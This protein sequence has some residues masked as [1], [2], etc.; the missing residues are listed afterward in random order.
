MKKLLLTLALTILI[1]SPVFSQLDRSVIPGPGPAPE[2]K[3]GEYESFEL[4]N[5]LKVFVV[6]NHKL[7]RVA[8]N[9]ILDIDPILE[10]NNAGYISATGDLLR[11]GTKTRTKDQIDNEVDFIGAT[12]N[13]SST[14]VY[15][16][17]LKKQV[18]KLLELM[19]DVVLNSEFKQE[20]LDKIK[21]Q[22]LS[23][24]AAQKKDPDAISKVVGDAIMYGKKHPYGEVMTKATVES[25]TKDMCENYYKTY[26]RPNAAY[27]AVVGDITKDEAKNLI[28][29]YF[30]N[31]EK[32]DVPK[33]N[34]KTPTQPRVDNVAIVDRPSS[35]QSVVSV[36]Y[37]VDL[38]K[39][40]PDVMPSSVMNTILGGS[41]LSRLNHNIREDKGWTYG[42][43]SALRSDEVI[44]Y[45]KAGTTVRNSVTDSTVT[46]ILYEMN[47]LRNEKVPDEELQST[48]NYI[49][50]SFAR[51]LENPQTI[52]NFALNI[53]RYDL[54]KNYYTNYLKNLN[55]VTADDIQRVAKE[56]LKTQNAY[57]VIVGN[58]GEVAD[59][60][61]KF[62]PGGLVNYYD[63]YGDP[64]DPSVNQIEEGV[65]VQS[66]IDAYINAI[67][68]RENIQKVHD[69]TVT[70]KGKAMGSDI[71]FAVYQ[72]APNKYYQFMD[73]G[74]FTQKVVFDG[75][76]GKQ[77]QMGQKEY[78]TG[79]ELES[80]KIDA[81][82]NAFL[83]YA[84]YNIKPKL[85]GKEKVNDKECYRV[86][87][88][89]PNGKK[90]TQYFDMKT[91][92]LVRQITPLDVEQGSDSMVDYD[93]YREIEGVKYP[94]KVTQHMGMGSLV[95]TTTAVDVNTGLD[96]SFFKVD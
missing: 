83:D 55:A 54:P 48:K 87:L 9:L 60:L 7:P 20:E 69:L 40:S 67:G 36:E 49:T 14:G 34:Y 82:M 53:A 2:I 94:F 63:T 19:S 77:E 25:V 50:G 47:K 35:V 72:K 59:K 57:I 29:K 70:M 62:N 93:D 58:A 81:Q 90:W 91:G 8:F 88:N 6:E 52:A 11:T 5:G 61:A 74:A 4:P 86:V 27:L 17:S 15:A 45:F 79:D 78:L 46:E 18:E 39:G 24:L 95:M 30:G 64:F 37:P 65:T 12:L 85:V 92:L 68:G 89:M 41:F 76:Q 1:A 10:G 3:L 33:H 44:G 73:A 32:Q 84:K 56:Y 13:T 71:T 26:F 22:M 75:I 42:A 23:G 38:K 51:A 43:G 28:T 16:E 96:D 80:L 21:T 66:V 31:W